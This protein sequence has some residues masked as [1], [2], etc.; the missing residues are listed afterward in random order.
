MIFSMLFQSSYL[1]NN[2]IHNH[3]MYLLTFVQRE[4]IIQEIIVLARLHICLSSI[5]PR[6]QYCTLRISTKTKIISS[7]SDINLLRRHIINNHFYHVYFC[8]IYFL[9]LACNLKDLRLFLCNYYRR[10]SRVSTLGQ[11]RLNCAWK[12]SAE[13]FVE[14]S[15]F[16]NS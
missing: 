10:S 5:T 15:L 9:E 8:A 1:F 3:P 13:F 2:H 12:M 6:Q 4:M 14:T 11:Q 16:N 7:V